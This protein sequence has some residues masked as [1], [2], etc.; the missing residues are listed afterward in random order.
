MT[1]SEYVIINYTCNSKH[2]L[3]FSMSTQPN[4]HKNL[5]KFFQKS[6][7][8][9]CSYLIASKVHIQF[10]GMILL[11][12]NMQS[13]QTHHNINGYTFHTTMHPY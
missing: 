2:F 3:Q 5:K 1:N 13:A 10:K 4:A 6:G 7:M 8:G 11:A 12:D 9:G